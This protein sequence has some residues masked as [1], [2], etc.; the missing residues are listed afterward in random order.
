MHVHSIWGQSLWKLSRTNTTMTSSPNP[1][2]M[3]AHARQLHK[4]DPTLPQS[5][6]RKAATC[7]TIFTIDNWLKKK[8]K[9]SY[10][11]LFKVPQAAGWVSCYIDKNTQ[12]WTQKIQYVHSSNQVEHSFDKWWSTQHCRQVCQYHTKCNRASHRMTRASHTRCKY[13]TLHSTSTCRPHKYHST[14]IACRMTHKFM[15]KQKGQLWSTYTPPQYSR[16]S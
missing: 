11:L 1:V 14:S 8:K 2:I 10:L 15:T 5:N 4:N 7:G 3:P 6:K 9:K 12:W 13:Q 16:T